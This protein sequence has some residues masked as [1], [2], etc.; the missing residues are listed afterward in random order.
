MHA[1]YC[2]MMLTFKNGLSVFEKGENFLQ[3]GIRKTDKMNEH[4][5]VF[6][7]TVLLLVRVSSLAL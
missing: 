7:N 4:C 1:R 6:P 5:S 2:D 3:N